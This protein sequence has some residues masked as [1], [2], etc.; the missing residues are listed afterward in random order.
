MFW[1][2]QALESQARGRYK[3]GPLGGVKVER[4]K[5]RCVV[6]I[7]LSSETGAW[8]WEARDTKRK[9]RLPDNASAYGIW[10]ADTTV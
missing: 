4:Q 6:C 2:E 9:N 7:N 3:R 5:K 8:L 10:A 1:R